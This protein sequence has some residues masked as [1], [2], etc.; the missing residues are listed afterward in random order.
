MDILCYDYCM[1]KLINFE[2]A[3]SELP[4]NIHNKDLRQIASQI[5]AE[6]IVIQNIENSGMTNADKVTA[7]IV[8]DAKLASLTKNMSQLKTVSGLVA[9]FD[10]KNYRLVQKSAEPNGKAQIVTDKNNCFYLT[11]HGNKYEKIV[12]GKKIT[13]HEIVD[14]NVNI[15]DTN[16]YIKRLID[17]GKIPANSILKVASCYV[18]ALDTSINYPNG[19]KVEKITQDEGEVSDHYI[20]V[21]PNYHGPNVVIMGSEKLNAA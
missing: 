3:K 15:L 11:G 17:E 16:E 12:D 20:T 10:L 18:S 19:V 7:R 9:L 13:G 8:H 2:K 1:G 21:K 4:K 14:R 5:Q 6:N